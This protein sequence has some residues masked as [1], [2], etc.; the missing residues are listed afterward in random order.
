MQHDILFTESSDRNRKVE[1]NVT[2][3]TEM[4]LLTPTEHV[5]R[6]KKRG[7]RP[8]SCSIDGGSGL[9]GL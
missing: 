3:Y 9:M 5:L 7:D 4:T 1:K 8:G 6:Q 2:E